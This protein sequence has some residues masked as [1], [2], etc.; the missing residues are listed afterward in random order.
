MNYKF[1]VTMLLF[2]VNAHFYASEKQLFA[3]ENRLYIVTFITPEKLWK[4]ER[5]ELKKANFIAKQ[6]KKDE[7]SY[8]AIQPKEFLYTLGKCKTKSTD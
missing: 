3:A 1:L 4:N 6:H 8:F 5:E 7:F 2:V